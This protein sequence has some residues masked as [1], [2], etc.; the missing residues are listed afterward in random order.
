[1]VNALRPVI[2]NWRTNTGAI[3]VLVDVTGELVHALLPP[4][5]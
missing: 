2:V 3:D 4:G 1:V 5:R